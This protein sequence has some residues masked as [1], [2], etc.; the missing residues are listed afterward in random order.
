M[1]VGHS[2]RRFAFTLV[3][4]LVVIGIIALLISVLLPALSRAREGAN[5]AKCMSNLRQIG[6]AMVMYQNDN[7]GY[8][9]FGA[10]GG[11]QAFE[12]FIYWEQPSPNWD[13]GRGWSITNP[14]SLD[15]GQLAKYMGRQF[16][17]NAWICPSDDLSAHYKWPGSPPYSYP[18]SYSMNWLLASDVGGYQVAMQ[19]I[20]RIPKYTSIRRASTTVVFVEESQDS[21]NDGI[22][23]IVDFPSSPGTPRDYVNGV[24]PGGTS[25]A[26]WMSVR[27]D[28]TVHFPV[29]TY[30]PPKD[31]HMIPNSGGRGHA[32]FVDGHAEYVTRDFVHYGPNRHWDPSA[33]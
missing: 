25:R 5:R 33:P 15:R 16:V 2:P 10:R 28:S 11:T 8:F 24:S 26:D 3:E 20:D 7:K 13:P 31:Q 12:D 29:N 19:W 30:K 23:A 18:F 17:T 32:S 1:K 14:R 6:T 21:I 27:H 22:F 4:L 9:P